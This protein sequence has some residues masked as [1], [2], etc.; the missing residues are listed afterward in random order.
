MVTPVRF[1]TRLSRSA[2][3]GLTGSAADQRSP[4]TRIEF[5]SVAFSDIKPSL[6]EFVE[7]LDDKMLR[8]VLEPS[9]ERLVFEW[10]QAGDDYK[11]V[12][13]LV[14]STKGSLDE[15]RTQNLSAF[16]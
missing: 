5:E 7:T 3:H 16:E 14:V 4:L 12:G 15:Y 10:A 1:A 2:S 13:S 8:A 6:S 11:Q 9:E